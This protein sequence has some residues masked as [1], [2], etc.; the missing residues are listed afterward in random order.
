MST[1]LHHL[2]DYNEQNV[3][4]ASN[5][6]FGVVVAEWNPE[7]TG[8]LLDGTVRT[9]EKHGA[10]PENIHIKTVPGSFELIYGAQQM[11]K[12]DGFDAIII[13]GSVIKGETPHFDYI[14]Q[15]V[16][17]GI[18]RL[19][20][21]QNIPVIYGLLTTNDLQQAKD[22]SGGRLGNKGDECAIDAIK[23][24]KF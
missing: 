4:D 9:L 24:A 12:N 22:R 20:A 14:C 8:A 5:M 11:T 15:G 18:A 1:E 3:P 10:I 13:L 23:M 6:C 7:I 16:T 19:N 17:Y 21:S 2:S